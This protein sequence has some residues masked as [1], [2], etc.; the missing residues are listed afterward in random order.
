[1]A[2]SENQMRLGVTTVQKYLDTLDE[3]RL[4]E[5]LILIDIM[6]EVT[7]EEPAMWGST[8]VGFGA[9]HYTYDSGREGDAPRLGF[10]TRKAKI[11]LYLT[12]NPERYEKELAEIGKTTHSK[13]CIHINKLAD[14]DQEKLRTLIEKIWREEVSKL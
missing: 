14:I 8:I 10:S 5:A 3:K 4:A 2:E 11:S 13:A 7:G 9:Y 1:M 6:R 12:Y